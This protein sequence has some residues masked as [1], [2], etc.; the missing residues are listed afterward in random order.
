MFENI[1]CKCILLRK[2]VVDAKSEFCKLFCVWFLAFTILLA[3]QINNAS[4]DYKFAIVF[5]EL[6]LFKV[7][8]PRS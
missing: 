4:F 6:T 2:N 1:Y 8:L 7:A 5:P 3:S